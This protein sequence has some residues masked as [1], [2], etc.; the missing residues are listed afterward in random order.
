M[1]NLDWRI[2]LTI[3]LIMLGGAGV[4]VKYALELRAA[5]ENFNTFGVLA[6][7]AIWGGCDWILKSIKAKQ[8]K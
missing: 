2:R 4:A 3:A 8:E 5:G 7:L 6:L 1:K